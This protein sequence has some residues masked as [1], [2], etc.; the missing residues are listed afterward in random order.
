MAAVAVVCQRLVTPAIQRP[1]CARTV[2]Q[3]CGFGRELHCRAF[4]AGGELGEPRVLCVMLIQQK[5]C[6]PL[7]SENFVNKSI[8]PN[9]YRPNMRPDLESPSQGA[10]LLY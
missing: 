3:S 8:E 9:Y 6:L 2:G 5:S 10:S 7:V 4:R 1:A